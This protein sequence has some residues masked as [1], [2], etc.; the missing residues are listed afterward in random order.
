MV[1][2]YGG[3]IC[4]NE[5]YRGGAIYAKGIYLDGAI[6]RNNHTT[7]YGG[8]FYVDAGVAT[9]KNSVIEGNRTNGSA[10]AI[11]A[12]GKNTKLIIDN[13]V[14]QD[15]YGAGYAGGAILAQTTG[16]QVNITNSQFV[17]NTIVSLGG[18]IYASYDTTVN[19]DTTTFT[20]NMA[21]KGACIYEER[22]VINLSKVVMDGNIADSTK[23]NAARRAAGV[24]MAAGELNMDD[25]EIKNSY[26]AKNGTKISVSGVAICTTYADKTVKDENGNDTKVREYA[27]L[28]FASGSI[29]NNRASSGAVL[30]QGNAE[31]NMS[32]GEI[33]G[34]SGNYAGGLYVSVG[35][36]FNMTGG[37]ITKNTAKSAGGGI[38]VQEAT[39]NLVSGTI[40]GNT[41]EGHGGAIYAARGTL[42][43]KGG[44]ITS[45][46]AKSSGGG[47]FASGATVNL[48]GSS[49]TY[50]KADKGSGGG[51]ICT[52]ARSGNGITYNATVNMTGGFVG[53]NDA[54]NGGGILIQ[55]S[56]K[57][58]MNMYGGSVA[59]NNSSGDAG[60]IYVSTKTT[61][62]MSGGKIYSNTAAGRGGAVNHLKSTGV[63]TG[64]EIY[65]NT[66]GNTAGAI[67][68][69]NV[70][71]HVTIKNMV[72]R[73]NDATK[74]GGTFQ[75]NG[76]AYMYLENV[77]IYDSES[78]TAGAIYVSNSH[79]FEA[80][81]LK[82]VDCTASAN[83]GAMYV[84]NDA[85]V[86]IEGLTVENCKAEGENGKGGAI[87]LRS[88]NTIITD[89]TFIGNEA[90]LNGG[91][92]SLW[93]PTL[94]GVSGASN[95]KTGVVIENALFQDN[96]SG[97]AGGALLVQNG[98]KFVGN[99]MTFEGNVSALEGAAVYAEGST[100]LNGLS[101][102]GNVSGNGGYAIYFTDSHY[103]GQSY[104]DGMMKLGGDLIVKDNQGGD[105]Y[106]GEMT[107]ASV[108]GGKVGEK[109]EMNITLAS[110][111]LTNKLYGEYDY[112]GGQ[113]VYKVTYGSRS[114]TEPEKDETL[115]VE[116]EEK[117]ENAA[118]SDVLLYVGV[119][120]IAL[121]IVA[122]AV[123]LIL[124]KKKNPTA[125]KA[126]Q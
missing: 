77:E 109:T 98:S 14:I 43:L 8:G 102:T 93:K 11:M 31:F 7:S 51:G 55:G 41:S 49:I 17:G 101:A 116:T 18:A 94:Q 4:N 113:L 106:M 34:N 21:E 119:G 1:N 114:L 33:T 111:V 61:L 40:S 24:Y 95:F 123:L 88:L 73:N 85:T 126:D 124:K 78:G 104:V 50:N 68:A 86:R 107:T 20:G 44:S 75:M 64:G 56:D 84:G 122:A 91:A 82:I 120:V 72:F 79:T 37:K 2:V 87:Y 38:Y 45:N 81:N 100:T 52:G 96:R 10:G 60:G 15:N 62:N 125:P 121:T 5:A 54:K 13:T 97:G 76:T 92:I 35:A 47:I 69:G 112:E 3:V 103:D 74:F 89:A 28:N 48:S 25:V 90:V 108:I 70:N 63:Y 110:G 39:V 12:S 30:L 29:S 105:V 46:V 80:K 53:H 6:I 67:Q 117:T 118:K 42:N 83:G 22:A 32:G 23:E 58:V 27:K 57:T 66:A 59:Y 16:T 115:L 26:G 36:T 9:V 19:I 65:D 71:T 99:N